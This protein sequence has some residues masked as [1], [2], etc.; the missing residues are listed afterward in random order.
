MTRGE[1]A[2]ATVVRLLGPAQTTP[3]LQLL[4]VQPGAQRLC[5]SPTEDATHLDYSAPGGEFPQVTLFTC[6]SSFHCCTV[7]HGIA[8][9]QQLT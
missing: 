2:L 9:L 4:G 5:S 7:C 6:V 1:N 8:I 3:V